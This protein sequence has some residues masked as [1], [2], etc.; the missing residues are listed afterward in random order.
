MNQSTLEKKTI[1]ATK[2][3]LFTQ[4]VSKLVS[5]VTQLVLAHLLAPEVFGVVSLTTMVTSFADMFSDAG[6]QKYLIQHDFDNKQSYARSANVAFWTN[7]G[8]SFLLWGA[9]LLLRNEIA[10]LLGNP[11]IGAAIG[12]ACASLPLTSAI[13]VQ[14]AV[15]QRDFDFKTLFYSRI[16]SAVLV[17]I[18]SVPLAIFGFGYWSMITGTVA[19]NF[20]LAIWLTVRSEWKPTIFYSFT[21]LKKMFA[22]SSWTLVEAFSVWLTNWMGTFILGSIMSAHYLGL[23]NTS[24]SLVN[25]VTG[26]VTSAV[27]PVI[28]SSLSRVQ[29]DRDR[30]ARMFYSMQKGLGFVVIPIAFCL[31]VFRNMIVG[32]YLGT[33]WLES[34]ML[35]GLYALS[36]AFVVVF[37]HT[38]SNAYRALGLPR[39]SLY[40]QL[41][42][43]AIQ[44]PAL[45]LGASR[46]F[47]DLSVIVPISR[48][49]GSLIAHFLI[50]KY[51][52]G[53]S[54]VKMLF[55]LRW[56]YTSTLLIAVPAFALV[57][58]FCNENVIFQVALLFFCCASYCVLLILV[59]GLRS[60]LIWLLDRF[61]IRSSLSGLLP[62]GLIERLEGER[63]E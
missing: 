63:D 1:G 3:S 11:Q 37:G 22:F 8:I 4:V 51:F 58:K 40:A 23:Y 59:R 61:G 15:Y 49:F 62:N 41:G 48:L 56:I 50:C 21:E 53:L 43:M 14:T 35:F 10:A 36:S 16:G 2:W 28:F 19:S 34:S 20:L 45:L 47:G 54:P 6:F 60:T 57:E 44:M 12:V 13:S 18:V 29:N 7:L 25:S 26:I 42:F 30:F 55:N 31:F 38:A 9:I 24:T 17:F 5:P 33:S 39:L 52:V 32:V 27:N 46:G